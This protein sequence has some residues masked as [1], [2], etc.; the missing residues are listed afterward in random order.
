MLITL[1][2]GTT[3]MRL[4]LYDG[5]TLLYELKKK[6]GGRDATFSG[7]KERLRIALKEAICELL[8]QNALNESDIEVI[9]CS[10]ILSSDVGIYY[11]PHAVAPC[12]VR[13][14]ARAAKLCSFEDITSIPILLI[15]GVKTLPTE[16]ETNEY[17]SIECM[18]SM[19][20]EECEVFGAME[21]TG[22]FGNFF[23]A[24][25][26]SYNKTIEINERGQINSISTGMCGE[27]MTA[28]SEYT[29]L[30]KTL[31]SPVIR[32]I[33][34]EKLVF[35]FDYARLHGMSSSLIKSRMVMTIGNYTPDEAANLFVG[36]LLVDDI[37]SSVRLWE[38]GKKFVVGGSAPLRTIFCILLRHAG[39]DD[40][41]E[42]D[43]EQEKHTSSLGAMKVWEEFANKADNCGKFDK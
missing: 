19:S 6:V 32:K 2:C 5:K 20:G 41:I 9:L 33:I 39:V 3:N 1:D 36:I 17:K 18:E 12:G 34:P 40:I 26:G 4:R 35:G 21:Q 30:K 14:S 8:R 27:M 43:D 11:I 15:P 23:V 31:P 24:L 16:G 37:M 38:K 29:V 25:P 7:D 10:G 28:M 13:E 22:L 42:I